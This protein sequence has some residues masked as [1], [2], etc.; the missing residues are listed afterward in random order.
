MLL[1]N[2]AR[3]RLHPTGEHPERQERLLG[4][5]GETVERRATDEQLARV[6]TADHLAFLRAVDRPLLFDTDSIATETSWEAAV[7]A[8]GVAR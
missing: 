6:H 2:P 7:L 3:A 5:G 8:V 1:T 4:L